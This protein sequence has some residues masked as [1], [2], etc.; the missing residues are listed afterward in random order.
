MSAVSE[1]LNSEAK[2]N[3]DY[4]TH[5]GDKFL[6]GSYINKWCRIEYEYGTDD[7]AI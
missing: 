6:L 1:K 3:S 2:M 7:I 4:T 5:I